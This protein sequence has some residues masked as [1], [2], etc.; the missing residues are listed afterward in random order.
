MNRLTRTRGEKIFNVFNIMLMCLIALIMFYPMWHILTAS[1]SEPRRLWANSGFMIGPLGWN[2]ASYVKVFEN[3]AI[4]RGY[5][6]TMFV[7]IVGTC[8]QMF[9]TVCCAFA[10][11]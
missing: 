9:M 2:P 3:P 11:T 8:I 1:I 10:L 6:N 4:P 7:V 5:I